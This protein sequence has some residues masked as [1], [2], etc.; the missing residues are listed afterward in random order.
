MVTKNTPYWIK[1]RH[2]FQIGI[3]YVACGQL[4]VKEAKRKE[5][6]LYGSNIMHRFN[7]EQSYRTELLRLSID[8]QKIT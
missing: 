7:T 3:Y 4:L 5:K 1:E 6:S 2:N 8:G